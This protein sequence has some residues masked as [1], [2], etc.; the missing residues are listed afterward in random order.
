[1]MSNRSSCVAIW[2][3]TVVATC[4][5]SCTLLSGVQSPAV[6]GETLAPIPG[7]DILAANLRRTPVYFRTQYPAGSIVI[8]TSE[9]YLYFITGDGTALRYGIAVGKEGY[10][11][12]GSMRVTKKRE[13]PDWRPPADMR[14]RAKAQGKNL[15]KVV[16]GG[17]NNPLGARAIYLGR[18]EYRIH[19]T[20]QPKSIGTAASSGCIRMLNEHVIDLYDRV[21]V[22]A[23]VAVLP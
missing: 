7:E 4:I 10:Q 1:M 19:G 2:R 18:S 22:R 13:W 3:A 8:D 9:K 20:T 17:P 5:L 12:E 6:G 14:A 16:K 11:W 23:R 15:P 21:R